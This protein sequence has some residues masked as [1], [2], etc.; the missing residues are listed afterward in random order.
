MYS[1]LYIP[2]LNMCTSYSSSWF[3]E[4]IEDVSVHDQIMALQDAKVV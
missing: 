1:I 2:M 3:R 4:N